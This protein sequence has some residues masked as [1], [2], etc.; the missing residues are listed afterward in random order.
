MDA[1]TEDWDCGS[2]VVRIVRPPWFQ[3]F[4]RAKVWNQGGLTIRTT[5]DPQ[6]QSSVQASINEHVYK[7]DDVAP[8]ATIVEPG[9]GKILAMGQSRPYGFGKHETQID[10]SVNQ[11]MGGGA[12]YQPGSTFKPIA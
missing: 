11:S 1:W 2:S 6:S 7:T 10:L 4:A 5:L 12:G 3:T 8:A 9:T